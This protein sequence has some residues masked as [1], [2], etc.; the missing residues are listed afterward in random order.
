MRELLKLIHDED[1]KKLLKKF[2]IW[3]TVRCILMLAGILYLW[4]TYDFIPP[5]RTKQAVFQVCYIYCLLML[6][7][8]V[9]TLIAVRK[10][11]KA[12]KE[13]PEE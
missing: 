5:Y 7:Y 10:Y 2:A 11:S 4:L 12:H 13:H 1:S 3:H 6:G 8:G 9:Q